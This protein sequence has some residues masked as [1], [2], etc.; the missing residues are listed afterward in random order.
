MMMKVLF[1]FLAF[2]G[3]V[4]LIQGEQAANPCH[5]KGV[6]KEAGAMLCD[7]ITLPP[8]FCSSCR[9]SAF[10]EVGE[11]PDCTS[12]M[13]LSDK[14]LSTMQA[15]VDRN[16]CNVNRAQHLDTYL[17]GS[18]FAKEDARLRLDW[19]GFSICEQGCDCIPQIDAD[20]STPAFDFA[21]GN[22]QA[23]AFHHICRLM[24]N[25]KLICLD[26]DTPDPPTDDLPFAWYVY[27]M[28]LKLSN[29]GVQL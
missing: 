4:V 23:H 22:C 27:C 16:P 17:N 1:V 9:I 24:P 8:G 13:D 7:Q 19:F 11:F 20:R 6:K 26:D 12:T 2:L 5:P 28:V 25:I 15:C 21:R 29:V 10:N 14:C 3:N 18:G